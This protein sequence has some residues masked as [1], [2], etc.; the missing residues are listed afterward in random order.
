M[1]AVHTARRTYRLSVPVKPRDCIRF[2]SLELERENLSKPYHLEEGEVVTRFPLVNQRKD[3]Y[4]T[5]LRSFITAKVKSVPMTSSCS[6]F[7]SGR[8]DV[9]KQ[10][11]KT[12]VCVCSCSCGV[13]CVFVFV[14][15]Y[16]LTPMSTPIFHVSMRPCSTPRRPH[17]RTEKL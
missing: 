11:T 13:W 4:H 14:C 8:K 1:T 16:S 6:M 10:K 2:P 12:D 7:D 3:H 17:Y 5:D 9:T 15:V